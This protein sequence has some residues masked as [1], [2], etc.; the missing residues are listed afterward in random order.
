MMEKIPSYEHRVYES[1][2][3]ERLDRLYL[4]NVF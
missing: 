2:D 4:E 3:D 1:V